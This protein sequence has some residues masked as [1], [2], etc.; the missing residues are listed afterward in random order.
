MDTQNTWG[1]KRKG[2]GRKPSPDGESPVIYARIPAKVKAKLKTEAGKKG[3]T[4]S[5]L[6]AVKLE[7]AT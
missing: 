6:V 4:L 1:G 3:L 2:A 7:M 5:K